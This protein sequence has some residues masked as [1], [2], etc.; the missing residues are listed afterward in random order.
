MESLKQ[1]LYEDIDNISKSIKE[2]PSE[3]LPE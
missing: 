2:S 1:K 3:N